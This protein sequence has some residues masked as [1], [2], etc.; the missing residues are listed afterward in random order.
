M[1]YFPPPQ[2]LD[3]GDDVL[4]HGIKAGGFAQVDV[5]QDPGH[6]ELREREEIGDVD[7]A[8]HLRVHEVA[9]VA[10]QNGK[11]EIVDD[12]EDGR[13]DDKPRFGRDHRPELVHRR[14]AIPIGH[15]HIF[16]RRLFVRRLGLVAPQRRDV[17]CGPDAGGQVP[18]SGSSRAPT[19][20]IAFSSCGAMRS[21]KPLH[22]ESAPAALVLVG[23]YS[24]GSSGCQ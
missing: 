21:S 12:E 17:R 16:V 3:F 14:H 24:T 18:G 5:G 23:K 10:D 15:I 9:G 6:E 1:A 7:H 8:D 4:R 22:T 11:R 13:R 2:R 20:A 19:C